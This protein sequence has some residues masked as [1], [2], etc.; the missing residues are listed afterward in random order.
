M[1][2]SES[3][4]MQSFNLSL[5]HL[6]PFWGVLWHTFL[7]VCEVRD[8]SVLALNRNYYILD[9]THLTHNMQVA[10]CVCV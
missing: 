5:D 6:R 7:G 10:L 1:A 8:L 2:Q 4:V 3:K 9:E